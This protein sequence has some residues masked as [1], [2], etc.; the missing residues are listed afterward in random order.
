MQPIT[1]ELFRKLVPESTALTFQEWNDI[2]KYIEDIDREMK[3]HAWW[4]GDCHHYNL[5]L[6]YEN[7][8]EWGPLSPEE[9]IPRAKELRRYVDAFATELYSLKIIG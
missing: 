4:L 8:V 3:R 7:Y 2:K 6:F 9:N 1:Q 5:K